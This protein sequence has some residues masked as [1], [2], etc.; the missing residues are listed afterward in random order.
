MLRAFLVGRGISYTLSPA[1]YAYAFAA[2]GVRGR[3]DVLDVG[4]EALGEAAASCRRDP[5]CL[6][7]NVTKPYKVAVVG[8]LDALDD[9]AGEVGAV[10]TVIRRGGELVGTNTDWYGFLAPLRRFDPPASYDEALVVG[11]GGAARAVVYALRGRA[12]RVHVVSKSGVTAERLA[13]LAR[14]MGLDARGYRASPEV[15]SELLP[16]ADLV[17]NASPA[18][19]ASESPIP[20]ALLRRLLPRGTT[21]VDLVYAPPDTLLLRAAAA[22]GCRTVDGLWVLAY[23]A[24][25]NLRL[26][27]GR[28]PPADHLRAAALAVLGGAGAG[29]KAGR[30]VRPP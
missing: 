2:L 11:A 24:E 28:S 1:I 25:M 16:R 3:Y 6:G 27:L 22:A 14:S 19:G 18:S 26:W 9:V 10:N 15:Y 8:H 12:S 13:G 29:D 7:F 21:V 17:V 20:P 4:P 5:S 30:A 23:Q